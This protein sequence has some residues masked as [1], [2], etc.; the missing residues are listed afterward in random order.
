MKNITFPLLTFLFTIASFSQTPSAN[1]KLSVEELMNFGKNKIEASSIPDKYNF[2]WKY[3]MQIISEKGKTMDIDYFLEPNAS[4]YGANMNQTKNSDMFMI[5]DSK[6]KMTITTFGKENKK[7]AMA[8][9]MTDYSKM[10][11]DKQKKLTYKSVTGKTILGYKC[12]GIQAT[13]DDMVITFYFTNDAK[14]SFADMFKNQ[15]KN[16]F[17]DA[18]K[19]F[20]K[21]TDR[22]LIL[23]VDYKDLKK[24]KSALMKCIAL[25]KQSYT[26]NKSDYKFM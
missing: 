12:K 22:P 21:P 2:N 15:K 7:M 25:E 5:V 3:T 26:F 6:N 11:D 16:S 17:P 9:K 1:K 14:V 20:F 18:F 13:N 19:E 10:T 23:E 24:N 4:Y 8:S